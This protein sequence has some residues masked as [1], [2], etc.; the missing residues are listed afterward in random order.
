MFSKI[1]FLVLNPLNGK[2][3]C[4]HGKENGLIM[5]PI[6]KVRSYNVMK[7]LVHL[8]G[9]RNYLFVPENFY[10]DYFSINARR[11]SGSNMFDPDCK[12]FAKMTKDLSVKSGFF[13]NS[14]RSLLNSSANNFKNL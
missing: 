1:E 4:L 8:R 6:S 7:V 5:R 11:V 10:L 2:D 12:A 9:I 14:S 13:L 3:F